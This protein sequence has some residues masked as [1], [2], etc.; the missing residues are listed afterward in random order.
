MLTYAATGRAGA[1]KEALCC[2]VLSNPV[3]TQMVKDAA[4]AKGI[5]FQTELLNFVAAISTAVIAADT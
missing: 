2:A 4:T 1:D 5:P 3:A